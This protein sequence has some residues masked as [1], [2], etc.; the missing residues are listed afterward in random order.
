M[1]V[2][3]ATSD[4]R[5]EIVTNPIADRALELAREW[6][7]TGVFTLTGVTESEAQVL[8]ELEEDVRIVRYEDLDRVPRC[9]FCGRPL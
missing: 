6:Y 3:Q 2:T 7:P 9:D 1:N 8:V 4:P 5:V